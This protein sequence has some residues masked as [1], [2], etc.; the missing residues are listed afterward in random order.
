MAQKQ[1]DRLGG[2]NG[3]GHLGFPAQRQQAPGYRPG[4]PMQPD[5]A[6]M[7]P[8]LPAPVQGR[9]AVA[10]QFALPAMS[11]PPPPPALGAVVRGANPP[12]AAQAPAAAAAA[13]PSFARYVSALA[14][15][16]EREEAAH[17][18]QLAEERR[19]LTQKEME[20]AAM[21]ARVEALEQQ[22]AAVGTLR[23]QIRAMVAERAEKEREN[24]ILQ[25]EIR[26]LTS[27]RA[28]GVGHSNSSA[29][30]SS[31]PQQ[32][33][34]AYLLKSFDSQVLGL[35]STLRP[36]D[37]SGGFGNVYGP[38]QLS[39]DGVPV[40]E[41]VWKAPKPNNGMTDEQEQALLLE[42]MLAQDLPFHPNILRGV[43]TYRAAKTYGSSE[44]KIKWTGILLPYAK[45]GNLH[46][47]IANTPGGN[48]GGINMGL[49]L[50]LIQGMFE[51]IAF[52]HERG[53]VHRDIKPGNFLLHEQLDPSNSSF[54]KGKEAIR[55][56]DF[57]LVR[58]AEENGMVR[59]IKTAGMGTPIFLAPE[60][61]KNKITDKMDVFALSIVLFM[62][63]T[64]KMEPYGPLPNESDCIR[65]ISEVAYKDLR[66]SPRMSRFKGADYP[67]TRGK[68]SEM[69]ISMWAKRPEDRPSMSELL[70]KMDRDIKPTFLGEGGRLV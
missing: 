50:G 53:K 42:E 68:I 24:Q 45:G 36:L 19:K 49:L 4:P 11:P 10:G 30:G 58:N 70:E 66:P 3:G 60:Y 8:P 59:T 28:A 48:G 34:A 35:A 20:L 6:A 21:R 1:M 62:M 38:I 32:P 22:Q 12:F 16:A 52:L 57:G 51:A 29:S 25:E 65:I 63:E 5:L 2:G 55:C 46:S 43:P 47:F 41:W 54:E 61:L 33:G 17:A 27:S 7:P 37:E 67:A 64:G 40:E 44:V 39:F 23:D 26:R 9:P 13:P 56:S 18:E 31:H 15:I 14:G 69:R